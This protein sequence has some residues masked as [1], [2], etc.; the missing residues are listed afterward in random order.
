MN[1]DNKNLKIIIVFFLAISIIGSYYIG[2]MSAKLGLSAPFIPN[3][4]VAKA[5]AQNPEEPKL[6][7]EVAPIKLSGNEVVVGDKNSKMMLVTYTD[8][9]CPFCAKFHPT[10]KNIFEKNS[11]TV[12]AIKHYPLPFHQYAKEFATMFECV[13]K[14]QG[15]PA[16]VK[17]GD[18]LFALNLNLQGNITN[19]EA[20]DLFV[21]TG[22]SNDVL[23][24]CKN[25]SDISKKI[26]DSLNEGSQLGIQGTPALYI[27]NTQTQKAVRINGALDESTIQAEFDKLKQ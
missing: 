6:I 22:L 20:N 15:S 14:N 1:N 12:L 23:N 16:A 18:N 10:L 21:K 27:I 8:F 19:K 7:E 5:P 2:F 3:S 24:N 25:D 26:A 13:A 9:Q 4:G 17:F 11:G